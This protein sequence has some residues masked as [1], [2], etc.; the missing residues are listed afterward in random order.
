ML[1][2]PF[3]SHACHRL[4]SK[5][6]VVCSGL[7]AATRLWQRPQCSRAGRHAVSQRTLASKAR[8][9]AVRQGTK[10]VSVIGSGNWGSAVCK[11]GRWGGLNPEQTLNP[12]LCAQLQW[13]RTRQN[14]P[15]TRIV[16]G[17]GFMKR[18][19]TATSCRILSTGCDAVDSASRLCSMCLFSVCREKQ[20]VKYLPGISL[21]QNVVAEPSLHKAVDKHFKHPCPVQLTISGARC[22]SFGLRLPAPISSR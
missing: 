12:V 20:N 19:L 4:H 14:C 9:Q 7:C 6:F 11:L 22:Y 17:C 2:V 15:T 3:R 16:Y 13:Q 5:R 10:S 8:P 21:G 1:K 18:K